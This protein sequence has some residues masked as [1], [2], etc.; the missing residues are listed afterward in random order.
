MVGSAAASNPPIVQARPPTPP[1]DSSHNER[2]LGKFKEAKPS[3]LG[4]LTRFFKVDSNRRASAPVSSTS[5]LESPVQ[6]PGL[7]SGTRKKRVG[8]SESTEYKD[9]PTASFDGKN[10][11]HIVQPLAPSSERK[12]AKSILKISSNGGTEHDPF[13]TVNTKLLPPHHHASF[14]TMLDSIVQQLGG[15]DRS[16]KMDAYLMFSGLLKAS[17]NVPDL[18]ALK[19]KMGL[20]CQFIIQDLTEK[21]DNGKSDTGLVVNSLVLLSSFLQKQSISEMF[22]ADFAV[23]VV[24]HAIKSFED[25]AASKEIIKHLMFIMAQQNFS[26][27]VMTADRVS[28]L[29]NSLHNIEDHIKGKSITMSRISIYRTLLRSSRSHMISISPWFEDMFSDM[30]SSLREVR[31]M[32]IAFGFEAAITLGADGAGTKAVMNLF[33]ANLGKGYYGDFYADRL[34]IMVKNKNDWDSSAVPQIWSIII[35]FLRSKPQ[36]LVQWHFLN[37]FLEVQQLSFNSSDTA[38]KTEANLAWNR[39]MYALQ[40]S[41]KTI[42]KFRGIVSSA[43]VTQLKTRKSSSGRKACLNSVYMLLYYALSPQ[44]SSAHLELFWDEYVIPIINGCLTSAKARTDPNLAKQD[45]L[46][47]CVILQSLF[48]SK[49][50]RKWNESRAIDSLQPAP[51]NP[52]ELPALDSKWLRKNNIRVF[53]VLDP[54][55]EMLY[56]DLGS[57]SGITKLWRTYMSS[58]GSPAINEVMVKPETMSSVASMFGMLHKFWFKGV[59]KLE[60][61]PLPGTV[62]T[63]QRTT[64]FVRSFENI[65]LTAA[66]LDGLQLAPF[67]DKL[68]AITQDTFIVVATPS[69]LPPKQQ[70]ETRCPLHHLILLLT[71]SSPGFEYDR[72]FYGMV[73]RI[74]SPFIQARVSRSQ[75]ELA[76]T[77]AHLLP[78]ESN[79]GTKIIWQVLAE[80]ATTAIDTRDSNGSNGDEP[81][82]SKYRKAVRILEI[83]ITLSPGSPLPAWRHLFEAAVNSVTLDAGDGGRAIGV[84]EEVAKIF[85]PKVQSAILTSKG[86]FYLSLLLGKANYPKDRQALES[87]HRKLWGTGTTHQKST[88]QDPYVHLYQY[89]NATLTTAYESYSKDH[90]QEFSDSISALTGMLGRCPTSLLLAVLVKVQPGIEP[91]IIDNDQR[92]LGGDIL[93]KA[94][95]SLWDMVKKMVPRLLAQHGH[96]QAL[97][98][99]ELLICAGL[100]SRHASR[101][102]GTIVFWNTSFGSCE[103]PF[104]YPE[105]V[106][107]A[108]LR[109]RAVADVQIPYLPESVEEESSAD[110]RQPIDFMETQDD[111][112]GM[113]SIPNESIMRLMRQSTPQV[114]I[115]SRRSMSLKR[116]RDNTPESSRRKSR[117]RDVTPRFRHDDSQVQFE[118]VESSPMADRVVDSQL[119]TDKQKETKERQHAEQ[120]MFPDLRST[121]LSREKSTR[122][123]EEAEMELPTH[124]SSQLRTKPAEERQTTPTLPIPSDDDGYVASSPTPTRS[125]RGEPEVEPE[126]DPPSSPPVAAPKKVA[127]V[128]SNSQF[129]EHT[130]E[131]VQP[132]LVT[133]KAPEPEQIE[134]I[135]SSPP[136]STP[137][138]EDAMEIDGEASN[139]QP[140]VS[141]DMNE[142][143]VYE[144]LE[145]TAENDEEPL[146]LPEYEALSKED[147]AESTNETNLGHSAQVEF[148]QNITMSTF[149]FTP[150]VRHSSPAEDDPS[151]QLRASQRIEYLKSLI[152]EDVHGNS[153]AP[154]EHVPTKVEP[155]EEPVHGL[156]QLQLIP[157]LDPLPPGSPNQQPGSSPV[158]FM[159]AQSSPTSSDRQDIFED[160]MSSPRLTR[161]KDVAPNPSTPDDY[162]TGNDSSFL[163]AVNAYDQPNFVVKDAPFVGQADISPRRSTRG[164]AS[165]ALEIPSSIDPSPVRKPA[166]KETSDLP[167]AAISDKEPV[168]TLP[169]SKSS[170]IPSLIPETPGMPAQAGLIIDEDGQEHDPEHTIVVD[171]SNLKHWRPTKNGRRK[172]R[173]RKHQETS[174]DSHEIPDSQDA[175]A[176]SETSSPQKRSPSK[177]SPAKK[178][179]RGQPSRISQQE[180]DV[181]SSQGFASQSMSVDFDGDRE[182]EIDG[183]TMSFASNA[184][185]EE[186]ETAPVKEPE[187]EQSFEGSLV[188]QGGA[189][190][191]IEK[192]MAEDIRQE[193]VEVDTAGVDQATSPSFEVIEETTID[194]TSLLDKS[195]PAVEQV[196][197]IIEEAASHPVEVP[198]EASPAPDDAEPVQPPVLANAE[199]QAE[200]RTVTAESMADKL[201]SLLKDLQ[202]AALSRQ[203][204]NKLEDLFFEA[205]RHM[206][207]A[208]ERGRASADGEQ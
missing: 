100:N 69:H 126:I 142:Q 87:A 200:D 24:E 10:I 7:A 154:A 108:L 5:A 158:H 181:E 182:M 172:S 39:L 149:E 67:T 116:S 132:A 191:E 8:W 196:D 31:T 17:D 135:P 38:T 68:L 102:S 136:V 204:V 51:M 151:E 160:A 112:Y 120:S 104:E 35:L 157:L 88:S 62:S 65:F 41:E 56:W 21:L 78:T 3:V 127:Y 45:A 6:T 117:K 80:F 110:Q 73:D 109:L 12:P 1:R 64:A 85:H 98:D 2:K 103:K 54:L 46:E 34:K 176:G 77:L 193:N 187:I 63:K 79:E 30:L 44:S 175:M 118:A 189:G 20:L 129:L 61:L 115:E 26:S 124:Q 40:L 139:E 83:G 201:Q 119:L 202:T 97:H 74:L 4:D 162:G 101:V 143:L 194:E 47:A 84:V 111:S 105:N 161:G 91:W 177:R 168:S 178:R 13:D 123:P 96:S 16:S 11:R 150:Q 82:G 42:P 36:A 86:M 72:Q 148:F 93:S 23:Q 190:V 90:L 205:K 138:S 18:K 57:D 49:T 121:P 144:D 164:S 155:E 66:S 53:K 25:A 55:M 145:F 173:K 14:A 165:K 9:P 141:G 37:D 197:D 95:A 94:V 208:E 43:L 106:K 60:S 156:Q 134:E 203:E 48:D 206:Y 171:T 183:T 27:K 199:A 32:A 113:S 29:V 169:G 207:A 92:L 89:I 147:G 146:E 152:E 76:C 159:D 188:E 28:R 122:K 114:I 19:S 174:G 133:S 166:L 58:I 52:S 198:D 185:V 140:Q 50:P 163:R 125:I 15:K 180:S 153:S 170:S 107:Q 22:P 184:E 179:A 99:L 70:V 186:Y 131:P 81:L 33:K 75:V 128:E 137:E 59:E 195:S 130:P 71:N 167:E 192:S